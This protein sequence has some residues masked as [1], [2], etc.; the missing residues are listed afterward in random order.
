MESRRSI[1]I[2][3]VRSRSS[4]RNLKEEYF[5]YLY[6]K[7]MDSKPRGFKQDKFFLEQLFDERDLG[8]TSG[9]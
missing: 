8:K 4:T 3:S 2:G 5:K 6:N 9:A 7:Q 1:I